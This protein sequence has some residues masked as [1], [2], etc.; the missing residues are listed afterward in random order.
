MFS[1]TNEDRTGN[2]LAPFRHDCELINIARIRATEQVVRGVLSH[3]DAS[4]EVAV[5]RLIEESRL[6]YELIGE[7]LVQLA[8]PLEEAAG[9]AAR[10]FME[11]PGH[12]ANILN[13]VFAGLAVG[14]ATTAEGQVVFAQIFVR[15]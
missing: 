10:A 11:S 14:A 15:P 9:E 1:L 5:L 6:S 8:A 2:G 7:N 12:R 3:M 13:P 4:G